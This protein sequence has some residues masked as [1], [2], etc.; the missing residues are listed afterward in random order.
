MKFQTRKA[1]LKQSFSEN[2][3]RLSFVIVSKNNTCKRFSWELGTYYESLNL[4]GAKFDELKTMFKDH[5]PSVDNA[6][7]RIE[8]VR[9]EDGELVC[10]C[11]FSEDEK[12][13]EIFKKYENGILSDVSIGYKIL[14]EVIDKK[15]NPK[16]SFVK[17]YE[18]YELSAV[19]KGADKFAKKREEQND[20]KARLECELRKNDLRLKGLELKYINK[21]DK[22]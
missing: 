12:S 3:K 21:K 13:L 1:S 6:I 20:E 19:W 17:S 16:T 7:A 4:E 15:A 14:D 18:I 8:N 9:L 10:D 11:V 2:E 5:N 22:R